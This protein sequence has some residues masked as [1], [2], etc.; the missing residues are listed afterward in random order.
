MMVPFLMFARAAIIAW[1]TIAVMPLEIAFD[2][3]EGELRAPRRG[4]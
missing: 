2:A 3:I 1:T 4:S